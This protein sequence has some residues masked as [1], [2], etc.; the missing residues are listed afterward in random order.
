MVRAQLHPEEYIKKAKDIDQKIINT[1]TGE[2]GPVEKRLDEFGILIDTPTESRL[3]YQGGGSDKEK[4]NHCQTY[5]EDI[6]VL[7]VF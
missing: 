1:P 5:R 3:R 7:S 2:R 4:R 6:Q